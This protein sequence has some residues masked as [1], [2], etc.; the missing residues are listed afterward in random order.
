MRTV[1]THFIVIGRGWPS[2]YDNVA[3]GVVLVGIICRC[4]DG[5]ITI[6]R[7]NFFADPTF[8]IVR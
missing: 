2:I 6:I 5:S 4:N 1:N 3:T 8:R 7:S